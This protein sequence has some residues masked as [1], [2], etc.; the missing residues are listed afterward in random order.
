MLTTVA[1]VHCGAEQVGIAIDEGNT[2]PLD[3]VEEFVEG[4]ADHSLTDVVDTCAVVA[5]PVIA[6]QYVPG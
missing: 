4:H 6:I 5:F 2:P 1:P 3:T